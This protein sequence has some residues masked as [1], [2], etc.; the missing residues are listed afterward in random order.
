MDG[1]RAGS[2]GARLRVPLG[3]V[4]AVLVGGPLAYR[5]RWRAAGGTWL[6]ALFMTTSSRSSWLEGRG[7]ATTGTEG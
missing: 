1:V 4:V 3:L 6:D 7:P 2:L 5:W